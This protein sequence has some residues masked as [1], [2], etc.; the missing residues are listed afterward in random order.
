MSTVEY[1]SLED[2]CSNLSARVTRRGT[3][4]STRKTLLVDRTSEGLLFNVLGEFGVENARFIGDVAVVQE[5]VQQFAQLVD[6][7]TQKPY[8]SPEG[9]TSQLLQLQ[10]FGERI[11]GRIVP[12]KLQRSIRN[13]PS[14]TWIGISSSEDW[15]PWELLHDGA[16]FLGDR[17]SLYRIPRCSDGG[18]VAQSRTTGKTSACSNRVVVHV[19]GGNLDDCADKSNAPFL[20]LKDRATFRPATKI[21]VAQLLPLVVDADIVHFT[22]HGRQ[23]PFYLQI[24]GEADASVNLTADALAVMRLKPGSLVFANA[25]GSAAAELTLGEALS[26]GWAVYAKGA[27]YIGTL[28]AIRVDVALRFADL[29]YEQL[30]QYG[31]LFESFMHAKRGLNGE[32]DGIGHLLYC[33]YANPI[34]TPEF[35][36]VPAK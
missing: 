35:G 13:W 19:I 28:G 14:E 16:G 32:D 1:I 3:N 31:D 10:G 36:F 22:C 20:K 2:P 33:I 25:C 24:A 7:L 9:R 8:R 15:I 5:G 27:F 23:K 6:D 18:L 34:E 29:F 26:F 21:V 4:W 11:F 17:F 30:A 12:E